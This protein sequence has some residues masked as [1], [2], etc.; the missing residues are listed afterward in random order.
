MGVGCQAAGATKEG[1]GASEDTR[2]STSFDGGK[3]MSEFLNTVVCLDSGSYRPVKV[4]PEGSN[5]D[6][7]FLVES[8]DALRESLRFPSWRRRGISQYPQDGGEYRVSRRRV[9]EV[10]VGRKVARLRCT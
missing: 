7:V 10:S 1:A 9:H 8:F 3:F 4:W 5:Y 2:L 6:L